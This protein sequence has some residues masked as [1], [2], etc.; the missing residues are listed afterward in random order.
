MT[1]LGVERFT[2]KEQ[3]RNLPI[4]G[5]LH[6]EMDMRGAP[7]ASSGGIRS[8]LDSRNGVSTVS[9][10]QQTCIALEVRIE[11]ILRV[12]IGWMRITSIRIPLPDL[13]LCSAHR[14]P[15]RI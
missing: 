7:V 10:G 2:G 13:H 9:V 15:S 6:L 4:D 5:S 14:F 1:I 11:R 8:R 3:L 12:R